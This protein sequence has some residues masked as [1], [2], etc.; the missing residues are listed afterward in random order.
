[1]SPGPSDSIYIRLAI[2]Y[3]LIQ[4][5]L[6]LWMPNALLLHRILAVMAPIAAF[7]YLI[8]VIG[9]R[10]E[11]G[12]LRRFWLLIAA[13]LA[14]DAVGRILYAGDEWIGG[15]LGGSFRL[16]DLFWSLEAFLFAAALIYLFRRVQGPLRGARF[17]LDIIIVAVILMTVGWEYLIKPELASGPDTVWRS[18]GGAMLYPLCGIVLMFF[19][20]VVY[21]NTKQLHKRA[22][23]FLC[24]G[25]SAFAL[26]DV[27][28]VFLDSFMNIGADLYVYP[29]HSL[30][31]CFIGFA[32]GQS[33]PRRG[34]RSLSEKKPWPAGTL[35]VRYL[36]PYSVLGGMFALMAHRFG[37]WSG[38]FTG[39]TLC[40]ILILI[41]QILIQVENDR[42]FER[43]HVSLQ[44]SESLAH[45]DDLTGLY[46]R[47]YFNARLSEALSEADRAGFRVG[48][49][50]MDLNR[51]KRV[52]DKYGHRAGDLLIQKVAQRLHSLESKGV[53]VSRLGG[54]EFTVMLYPAGEDQELIWMAEDIWTMLSEPYDL[55]GTE[56]Y[57]SPSI[58]IAVYPDHAK[59]DQELI[60]RADTAMYAAKVRNARW[61]FD[62]EQTM[63]LQLLHKKAD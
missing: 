16:A 31:A 61:H 51:F 62:V 24:L 5:I 20:L 10:Y 48:L 21:F 53:I 40:F 41:R 28:R 45:R 37:G 47:R 52:N 12:H 23:I 6:A 49:L 30:S 59:D 42:L 17:T 14:G 60:G 46:N 1:M 8:G 58:G 13:G 57:T 63:L 3:A 18:A 11:Q 4:W 7:A 39:L 43:L 50:Y 36:L 26:G 55:E 29:L 9:S 19:T 25:G 15:G 33:L 35:I 2:G 34:R 54:D 38:L 56:I 44:K 27:L 22:V 32:G